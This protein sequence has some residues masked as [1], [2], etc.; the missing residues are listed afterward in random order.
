MCDLC[1]PL[2]ATVSRRT[3]IGGGLA[4]AASTAL[5]HPWH[6]AQAEASLPNAIHPREAWAGGDAPTGD[7]VAE[8]DVRFLLVH[9]TAGDTEHSRDE[10]P[11]IIR[12][13][14]R[15][16]TGPD[17]QWPDVAYNFVVD[18]YGG[19]WEGRAGSLAGA[20]QTDA[21]GGSQ[22]FAQ[23]VCLIGDFTQMVPTP[24]ATEALVATLAWLSTRFGIDTADGA[25]ATFASRGS[26]LHPLGAS[27]TTATITGHRT[28]SQTACPGDAFFPFV[29]DELQ[30]VV[31]LRRAGQS[32]PR[33]STTAAHVSTT[34]ASAAPQTTTPQ[35]TTPQTTAP[36]TTAQRELT[37]SA[38]TPSTPPVE[39]GT[40]IHSNDGP[41][42]AA[43]VI[44][45]G[46]AVVAA[47]GAAATAWRRR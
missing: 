9:H 15:F 33:P 23:L 19:V 13:I 47:T 28:M 12:G 14:H 24:D 32:S 3:L 43:A 22:G 6:R 8:N 36:Q 16:H 26:N 37:T 29:R 34:S 4:V 2:R 10:V 11:G 42:P 1:T 40:S 7:L 18:R 44:A 5:A 45:A 20:V 27:V 41:T 30:G 31:N 17:K 39:S 38:S 25:T 21:T 35:T 46:V